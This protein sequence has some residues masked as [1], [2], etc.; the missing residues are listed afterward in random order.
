[1]IDHYHVL[2]L[3]QLTPTEGDIKK[4]FRKLAIQ[5][6]PDKCKQANANEVFAAI[7]TAY[8]TLSDVDTKRTYD[9]DL[10]LHLSSQRRKCELNGAS[11]VRRTKE[12]TGG[13][14]NVNFGFDQRR[15]ASAG[16]P[17]G[18]PPSGATR[19]GKQPPRRRASANHTRREQTSTS[20]C[21]S[22]D[23]TTS[24]SEEDGCSEYTPCSSRGSS[25]D[26]SE[27]GGRRVA[28]AFANVFGNGDFEDA[29]K[30]WDTMMDKLLIPVRK[31]AIL[32]IQKVWRG[33]IVRRKFKRHIQHMKK[34][35]A[36]RVREKTVQDEAARRMNADAA[37]RL[38]AMRDQARAQQAEEHLR[39][40]KAQQA[41]AVAKAKEE[42]DRRA[43]DRKEYSNMLQRHRRE[44][45]AYKA[46]QLEQQSRVDQVKVAVW[47][48]CRFRERRARQ[49][50]RCLRLID[51]QRRREA[52]K[53]R[54]AEELQR[55]TKEREEYAQVLARQR[56]EREQRYR[57]IESSRRTAAVRI[58]SIFRAYQAGQHVAMVRAF[59]IRVEAKRKEIEEANVKQH[60]VQAATVVQKYVR[61]RQWRQ[62]NHALLEGH[63]RKLQQIKRA[64]RQCRLWAH[65][66]RLATRRVERR[67]AIR[68]QTRARMLLAARAAV[69]CKKDLT[70]Q[71][72][73][74]A[75]VVLQSLGRMLHAI[76]LAEQLRMRN[77][78]AIVLQCF[79]RVRTARVCT[80]KKKQ[81]RRIH[82]ATRIQA[83]ARQIQAK[84]RARSMRSAVR[85][86]CWFRQLVAEFKLDALRDVEDERQD[87]A[88]RLQCLTRQRSAWRKRQHLSHLRAA[89][90]ITSVYR[91]YIAKRV[92]KQLVLERLWQAR[93]EQE[94][95]ARERSI[96]QIQTC[97]RMHRAKCAA[98]QLSL[99]KRRWQSALSIQCAL[100]Q[101]RARHAMM[102]RRIEA[103]LERRSAGALKIETCFRAYLARLTVQGKRRARAAVQIQSFRRSVVA[104]R[105][106]HT[107]QTKRQHRATVVLQ[108]C[109]RQHNSRRARQQLAARRQ[110]RQRNAATSI[111][112]RWRVVC[113][114]Q[115]RAQLVEQRALKSCIT[116]Q[117]RLRVLFAQRRL[118]ERFVARQETAAIRIQCLARVVTARQKRREA[119]RAKAA[120]RIQSC[121]RV[122]IA[123]SRLTDLQRAYR[124][125]VLERTRQQ[126]LQASV[127]LQAAWRRRA[128][129]RVVAGLRRARKAAI[130]FAAA[131]TVQCAWRKFRS[132]MVLHSLKLQRRVAAA[133]TIQML[134]RLFQ[135]AVRLN[136]LF[137]ARVDHWNRAATLI[138]TIARGYMGQ[139]ELAQLRFKRDSEAATAIQAITRS[140]LAQLYC[141]RR[142][143]AQRIARLHRSAISIQTSVRGLLAK[144]SLA[145]QRKRRE[146]LSA[147]H[148]RA[149][150]AL[151]QMK[152]GKK[153]WG[154]VRS[155]VATTNAWENAGRHNNT[156]LGLSVGAM[157]NETTPRASGRKSAM[158]VVKKPYALPKIEK[159]KRP[160]GSSKSAPERT[161]AR[162]A[163]FST[164]TINLH[165]KNT[166]SLR[167]RRPSKEKVPARGRR[168][169]AITSVPKHGAISRG[170][171]MNAAAKN[172][173][174]AASA[175][176]WFSEAS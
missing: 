81:R 156:S 136:R 48:Q 133:W 100:R 169:S 82:A 58:Q 126:R 39:Q 55:L 104:R 171:R 35:A 30:H 11:R 65:R 130:V 127:L 117:C 44:R 51:K 112:S 86:Q 2:G 6:H 150:Q 46:R 149:I 52:K 69:R 24:S 158:H 73:T 64:Q 54:R 42:K 38:Q 67:A 166:S 84:R 173:P 151:Q 21:S 15:S 31:R 71:R 53:R 61:G 161:S 78:Q 62:S 37:R 92:V 122:M 176:S 138:Q 168:G 43:K 98:R 139:L 1:M 107:L 79:W 141:Q 93:V 105:M 34:V 165:A 140:Y 33:A 120:C 60:Q 88:L 162:S 63:R 27:R 101:R 131:R 77:E 4:A 19:H 106:L 3:P 56:Q 159:T 8:N 26:G 103:K 99:Q 164:K 17:A 95:R 14:S 96:V 174:P 74:R 9:R 132:I 36:A 147:Q 102:T 116:L 135:A 128:A 111:Q 12:H 155:A 154:V 75:A 175:V 50:L 125:V 97:F 119:L 118:Q 83:R 143:R 91:M 40:E 170:S 68:L 18:E 157:G 115:R 72:R 23:S 109:V 137:D 80:E 5:W 110:E 90:K 144:R 124:Q 16:H 49:E 22:R 70:A 76:A 20:R 28:H 59:Q 142:K 89:L 153:K 160:P 29:V 146:E 13:F 148:A 41:A 66:R 85:I 108:C 47:V 7:S 121:V 152:S 45:A 94:Q 172:L 10:R 32:K 167:T 123:Q 163:V 87:A 134:V 57:T 129:L 145:R 113:A 114:K 25:A